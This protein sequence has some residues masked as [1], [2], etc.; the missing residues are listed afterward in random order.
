M[1]YEGKKGKRESMKNYSDLTRTN[2]MTEATHPAIKTGGLDEGVN[3]KKKPTIT[4]GN[5]TTNKIIPRVFPC[6]SISIITHSTPN[7]PLTKSFN[8]KTD[9]I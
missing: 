9:K 5:P 1:E 2:P 4:V 7:F 8:V 3:K 6:S